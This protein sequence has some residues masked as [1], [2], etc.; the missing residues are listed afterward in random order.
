M[1]DEGLILQ[2]MKKRQEIMNTFDK[3]YLLEAGAGA[4]KTTIIVQRILNHIINSDIHPSNIVAI[5]FTKAASTE[6]AERI[7]KKALEYLKDGKYGNISHRLEAVDEI[8]TGTI[9]SFCELILREMPFEAG[10]TPAYEIIEDSY[11]FHNDIWYDFLRNSEKEYK[12]YISILDRFMIDYRGLK[13]KAIL[14]MENPDVSFVGYEGVDYNFDDI[15]GR[16]EDLK[17]KHQYLDPNFIKTN[18]NF[19]RLLRAILEDGG[20]IEDYMEIILKECSK[21]DFDLE[22]LYIKLIYKKHLDC[23]NS[24]DYRDL[25]L[26]IY[27]IYLSLNQ[28]AYNTC[29]K[30]INLAVEYKNQNYKNQLTFNELLYKASKLIKESPEARKH[31]KSKY[32]YF[33]VDEF[34]DTD[35]M[36]AELILYLTDEKDEHEETMYWQDCVPRPGSL[37]VVGDPKQSIYRFRRAD[38]LIYNQVKEIID[39]YG[40]VTYLDINF[41]S[42]D[43]ICNWVQ[44]TF[45]KRDYDFGFKEKSTGVQAGFERILSLWDDTLETVE[46]PLKERKHLKGIYQYEVPNSID[47][48]EFT[49]DEETYVANIVEYII[50]NYYIT[51]KKS[52]DG[53]YQTIPRK[54]EPK[55]I[56]ILT[57]SNQETGLYLRAL[58]ERN[59]PALLA[60]EKKLGDTREVLNLFILIDAILDYRDSIKVVSALRNSFYLDLETIDLFMENMDNLSSIIFDEEKIRK[61]QHPDISQAF[62][63]MKEIHS[64]ATKLSPITFIETLVENRIGIY[65]V[66]RDYSEIEE[67]DANSALRQTI[68]ILK[69]KGCI[70]LFELRNELDKLICG[71]VTY[72]LPLSNKFANNAARVMN[73][74]KSKGLEANIVIL[75]GGE[76]KRILGSDSHYIEKS[77]GNKNLGYMVYKRSYGLLGPDEILR[78][79]R[80]KAFKDAEIDRLLYVAATRTKSVLMVPKTEEEKQFLYPLSR[81][82]DNQ[83]EVEI[84]IN[85]KDNAKITRK[86]KEE[87][88]KTKDL[89]IKKEILRPSYFKMSPSEFK[90]NLS[91]EEYITIDSIKLKDVKVSRIKEGLEDGSIYGGPR[92]RIYGLM[93]HRAFEILIKKANGLDNIHK[94]TIDYA[95]SLAINEYIENLELN[96][97]NISVFY[98]TN[99]WIVNEILSIKEDKGND[100]ARLFLKERLYKYIKTNLTNFINNND[101][102]NL[103][104]DSR[105]IFTE[106]PFTISI[107]KNKDV[108]LNKLSQYISYERINLVKKF[109]KPILINGVIDLVIQSKDGSW[110]ILDYKTDILFRGSMGHI[111]RKKYASQL[112][113]YK[114]LLEDI[115]GAEDIKIDNLIIYSTFKDELIH[116]YE[117]ALI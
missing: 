102:R 41:R 101:I 2:E 40:E 51:E 31:F 42:T 83:L 73:I 76:K 45:K 71:E 105:R 35:P 53:V 26:G 60:G 61:I 23:S 117:P 90:S 21:L 93:V 4:G 89:R 15:K 48:K 1:M 104:K 19:S 80:E 46:D 14:A 91:S 62:T 95:I 116:I 3:N 64:L 56:M 25:I 11:E 12:E 58:K 82:I 75:V 27:N 37:F 43:R 7:Q 44:S 33:Y 32:R 112:K 10:L 39:R 86:K 74:H 30:F 66:H 5:T 78:K 28:L 98:P 36:Q 47:D 113:G 85:Y 108:L 87:L 55:D 69:F 59:I 18:S 96:R 17:V 9:H 22:E 92:G 97:S 38:I 50:K 79:E 110:T 57:K 29:T 94:D 99:I 107:D 115:L 8:F 109:N 16:F 70:S 68:E 20:H 111:L 88:E 63:Y 103:F 49:I 24:D 54:V 34:Q 84:D 52:I 100:E 72:E 77:S 13:D 114:I 6:L 106:L 67:R 65:D 81:N